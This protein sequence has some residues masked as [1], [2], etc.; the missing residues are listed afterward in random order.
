[1]A[2]NDGEHPVREMFPG[3]MVPD[4]TGAAGSTGDRT[5]PPDEDVPAGQSGLPGV[6]TE[7][8]LTVQAGLGSSASTSQPGQTAA[9]VISPGPAQDYAD[10]GAGQGSTDHW[11]RRDYQQAPG[12]ES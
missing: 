1:V 9:S 3:V 6:G 11:A 4:S 12:D 8:P 10:T 2:A 7:L 5:P